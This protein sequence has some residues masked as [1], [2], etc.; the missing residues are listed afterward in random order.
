[1]R[2][3][4]FPVKY[5][6]F[7]LLIL[8]NVSLKSRISENEIEKLIDDEK[9]EKALALIHKTKIS[10]KKTNLYKGIIYHGMYKPDSAIY[11]LKKSY[12]ANIRTDEVLIKLSHALL[13]KKKVKETDRLLSKVK[14]KNAL[15]F[16]KVLAYKHEVMGELK[17][18]LS[19]YDDIIKREKLPYGT[20]E[21]KAI[22]L[23]WDKQYDA[24]IK[25]LDKIIDTKIVSKPLR[26]R[27][28]IHKAKVQSWKLKFN[29]ALES[30]NAALKTDPKNST[31]KSMK[32]PPDGM[33]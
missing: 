30:L 21:R 3:Y 2:E 5:I 33:K 1:M 13:W 17:K 29:D 10:S 26:V 7:T 8:S 9:F 20:M 18:A 22:V 24:S 12:K 19:I 14:D 16:M 25:L 32:K 4:F 28:L 23:S 15:E 6:L 11:Y 27:C 31:A